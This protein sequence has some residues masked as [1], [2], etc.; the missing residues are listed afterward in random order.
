M[1]ETSSENLSDEDSKTKIRFGV[2]LKRRRAYYVVNIVLP[3][4]KATGPLLQFST[5]YYDTSFV[6]YSILRERSSK[7]TGIKHL[8][9]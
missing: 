1:I 8:I 7:L 5:R 9:E 3:V 4:S 2:V 6:F